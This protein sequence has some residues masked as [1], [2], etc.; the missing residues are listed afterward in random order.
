MEDYKA[1]IIRSYCY[2]YFCS[3]CSGYFCSDYCCFDYCCFACSGC[4]CSGCYSGCYSGCC[5]YFDLNSF[6]T[7]PSYYSNL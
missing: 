1:T 5:C 4:F 7:P 6:I 3:D 2:Y